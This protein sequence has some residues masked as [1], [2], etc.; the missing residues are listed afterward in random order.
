M[1]RRIRA[2][3]FSGLE[4]SR[5]SMIVIGLTLLATILRSIDLNDAI[6][7]DEAYSIWRSTQPPVRHDWRIGPGQI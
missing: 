1:A 5:D 4:M 3:S 2:V 7:I 6:W